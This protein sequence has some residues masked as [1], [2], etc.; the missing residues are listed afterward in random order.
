MK[1]SIIRFITVFTSVG[2]LASGTSVDAKKSSTIDLKTKEISLN[3]GDSKKL[4]F[5]KK[6]M[7]KIKKIKRW[8]SADKEIATVNSK[9][10]VIGV[11]EGKTN[12][13]A[14]VK[15]KNGKTFIAKCKV[16]VVPEFVTNTKMPNET[17]VPSEAEKLT[18]D[19]VINGEIKGYSW[20]YENPEPN[21]IIRTKEELDEYLT[22]IRSKMS[23]Y[24][25]SEMEAAFSN[26]TKDFFEQKALCIGTAYAT[27]GLEQVLGGIRIPA[28][29]ADKLEITVHLCHDGEMHACVMV[30]Y[31]TL[32][33]VNK[34][35]ISGVKEVIF[36]Y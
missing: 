18:I 8:K 20:Y 29:S 17:E 32:V 34:E 7:K 19:V 12:I 16:E 28:E 1:K 14:V 30:E 33:E 6:A 25:V 27:D 5:A 22:K 23:P 2:L 26:Y 13:S 3:V 4:S 36:K 11:S 21:V 15:L 9:G 24:A 31:V 35:D 10:K